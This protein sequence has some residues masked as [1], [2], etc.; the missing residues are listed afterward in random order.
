MGKL[1]VYEGIDGS[2]KTTHFERSAEWLRSKDYSVLTLREPSASPHGAKLRRSAIK[3]RLSPEEELNLFIEDRRWNV[4]NNIQPALV[5]HQFVL[6]DR[7]YYS[8]IAYQGTRG[9]DLDE[10]RKKNEAFAPKPNLVLLFDLSPEISI[11]RIKIDRGETP[12][13]FE[14]LDYLSR[15]RDIFLSL[16]DEAIVRIDAAKPINA[17]WQQVEAALRP[18]LSQ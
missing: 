2:G 12:N 16:K 13:L 5:K 15:V 1:I 7:Y 14:K 11:E 6:L 18:L 3:G 10:I 4:A 17:V 8:T 9:I